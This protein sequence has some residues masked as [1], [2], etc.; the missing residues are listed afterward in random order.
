MDAR[1]V[2]DINGKEKFDSFRQ[3]PGSDL[4]LERPLEPNELKRWLGAIGRKK[5][6][7]M[8]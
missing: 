6:N 8:H 1:K 4:R 5:K 3:F 7:K 2:L